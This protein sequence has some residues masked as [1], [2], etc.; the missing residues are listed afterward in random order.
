M[1]DHK[2]SSGPQ[3]RPIILHEV[4]NTMFAPGPSKPGGRRNKY[5]PQVLLKILSFSVLSTIFQGKYEEAAA[6]FKCHR[7]LGGGSGE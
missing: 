3:I 4:A 7:D 6:S 2:A 5:P 1:T